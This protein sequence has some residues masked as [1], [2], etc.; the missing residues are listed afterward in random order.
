[1][2]TGFGSKKS[3]A[4]AF[5]GVKKIRGKKRGIQNGKRKNMKRRERKFGVFLVG[6]LSFFKIFGRLWG[7]KKSFI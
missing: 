4:G 6:S 2:K 5:K 1:M 7:K 3:T